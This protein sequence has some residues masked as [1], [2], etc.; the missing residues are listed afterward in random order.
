MGSNGKTLA[1][2]P[3]RDIY[4]DFSVNTSLQSLNTLLRKLYAK[5]EKYP[6]GRFGENELIIFF[7][8]KLIFFKLKIEN[9]TKTI[10]KSS[11]IHQRN[12]P[13]DFEKDPKIGCQVTGVAGRTD[14]PTDRRRARAIGPLM[15]LNIN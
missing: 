10:K 2:P 3:Q 6:S 12:I 4:S 5:I 15:D 7:K 8:F 14:P 13:T 1:P 11:Y 9:F